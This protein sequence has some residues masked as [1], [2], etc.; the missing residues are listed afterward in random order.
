MGKLIISSLLIYLYMSYSYAEQLTVIASGPDD[1]NALTGPLGRT[2]L[3]EDNGQGFYQKLSLM[4][5]SQT[6]PGSFVNGGDELRFMGQNSAQLLVVADGLSQQSATGIGGS[7]SYHFLDPFF[8]DEMNIHVGGGS[9]VIGRGAFSGALEFTSKMVPQSKFLLTSG[10]NGFQKV[11]I[12][13]VFLSK[14]QAWSV[15]A[16]R[17][18]KSGPSLQPAV[19]GEPPENDSRS[20]HVFKAGWKKF[21][22][23]DFGPEVQVNVFQ[24]NQEFDQFQIDDKRPYG[25]EKSYEVIAKNT[26]IL[27]GD[28]IWKNVIRLQ[29][30][31]RKVN[32]AFGDVESLLTYNSQSVFVKTS[33]TAAETPWFDQLNWGGEINQD[34][35]L[36]IT[37]SN[38]SSPTEFRQNSLFANGVIKTHSGQ[39]RLGA[40]MDQGISAST[41]VGQVGYD[42]IGSKTKLCFQVGKNARFPSFY[43][44]FSIYGNDDLLPEKNYSSEFSFLYQHQNMS[45]Q[46]M[47]FYQR[48][49]ELIYYDFSRSRYENN[50]KNNYAG[51]SINVSTR[52]THFQINLG[53]S[54]TSSEKKEL[55]IGVSPLKL[56]AGIDYIFSDK[57]KMN[58]QEAFYS[59]KENYGG[60]REGFQIWNTVNLTYQVSEIITANLVTQNKFQNDQFRD[61]QFKIMIQGQIE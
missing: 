19:N 18:F 33:L 2:E 35:S 15:A 42:F 59:S 7:R 55:N 5:F 38:L 53:G 41:F 37:E 17:Q 44:L 27:F 25:R 28:Q 16:L 57:W 11:A 8:Y 31:S 14:R 61:E 6:K 26:S 24:D 21:A 36:E 3:I 45:F 51:A 10:N 56:Q 12:K 48:Q 29:Q 34:I 58:I 43:E 60:T 40:R 9:S 22:G 32:N 54:F 30:N 49:R 46:I 13:K 23:T 52:S 20:L 39:W 1:L 4:P 47:G 50:T